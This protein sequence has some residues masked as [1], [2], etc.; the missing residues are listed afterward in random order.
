[1]SFICFFLGLHILLAFDV[2]DSGD[3]LI[4]MLRYFADGYDPLLHL[5]SL[6]VYCF[7]TLLQVRCYFLKRLD[8]TEFQT[9]CFEVL[10][11]FTPRCIYCRSFRFRLFTL[12]GISILHLIHRV[13]V[14]CQ[15]LCMYFKYSFT[16]SPYQWYGSHHY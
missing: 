11:L 1:M 15:L 4:P 12:H 10:Y 7:I 9:T 5:I 14:L 16:K 6:Y 13:R 3:I 2:D 8:N